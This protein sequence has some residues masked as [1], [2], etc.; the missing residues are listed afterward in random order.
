MKKEFTKADLKSGMVVVTR[1][2]KDNLYIVIGDKIISSLG[3]VQLN[4]YNDDLTCKEGNYKCDIFNII[5]VYKEI[6]NLSDICNYNIDNLTLIWER[7]PKPEEMTL[8][9]VCAALGKQI[10]IVP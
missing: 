4:D 9:E 10:K 7:N 6:S 5:K 8:E 2:E 3:Y 1:E